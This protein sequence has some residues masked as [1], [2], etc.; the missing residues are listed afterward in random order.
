ER[1][2]FVG[3]GFDHRAQ[4]RRRGVTIPPLEPIRG[5]ALTLVVSG[6]ALRPYDRHRIFP[7]RR[8]VPGLKGGKL[9]PTGL[10]GVCTRLA[11]PR[12]RV[13][14]WVEDVE[15]AGQRLAS[16]QAL[17]AHGI[18]RPLFLSTGAAGTKHRR[19]NQ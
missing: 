12:A 17:P 18:D 5:I 13:V 2:Q 16:E 19:R 4:P 15:G 11:W 9:E 1:R 14:S 10:V 8:P 6:S 7:C 3:F